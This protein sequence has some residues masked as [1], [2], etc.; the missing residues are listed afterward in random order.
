MYS[1]TWSNGDDE[2][3]NDTRDDNADLGRNPNI[4]YT[5][6][7][8][9]S[10]QSS[11]GQDYLHSY[12]S[13]EHGN[14]GIALLPSAGSKLD[15]DASTNESDD[16]PAVVAA[17]SKTHQTKE[18]TRLPADFEPTPYS[19]I[20]GKGRIPNSSVGNQR[21]RVLATASLPKYL[22]ASSRKEKTEVISQLIM[23]V[24]E[25]SPIGSF[26]KKEKDGTWWEVGD[27]VAREKIGYIIRDL[28]HDRYRS[29]S[30]SKSSIR[31]EKKLRVDEE[32]QQQVAQHQ[33]QE[34]YNP[35]SSIP[36]DAV[37]SA[38]ASDI[39]QPGT[40]VTSRP[41]HPNWGDMPSPLAVKIVQ[42]SQRHQQQKAYPAA[43]VLSSLAAPQHRQRDD[44][45]I[46]LMAAPLPSSSPSDES[47]TGGV[48]L[49]PTP[50]PSYSNLNVSGRYCVH[51]KDE[52][53]MKKKGRSHK[54]L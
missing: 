51:P 14:S 27:Q 30:K 31:R 52:K 10:K 7:G 46:R 1:A 24:R 2:S 37:P 38:L 5:N 32:E 33:R 47:S 6:D 29:S 4:T 35:A 3:Y 42:P 9:S 20:V 28:L 25:A 15:D 21:L 18:Q 11:F 12:S 19:V 41:L 36:S 17:A 40:P 54:K 22:E 49:E 23:T 43:P 16:C 45:L 44:D 26:V 53:M 13:V 48:V 34:G 50:F 8:S 39:F